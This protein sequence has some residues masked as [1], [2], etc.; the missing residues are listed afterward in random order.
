MFCNFLVK[1]HKVANNSQ[2]T[3]NQ[4]ISYALGETQPKKLMFRYLKKFLKLISVYNNCVVVG[5][6]NVRQVKGDQFL[7]HR[8]SIYVCPSSLKHLGLVCVSHFLVNTK[9]HDDF[10]EKIIFHVNLNR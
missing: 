4:Y 8:Y 2:T 6:T 9:K 10:N 5:P 1:N 3:P 7:R